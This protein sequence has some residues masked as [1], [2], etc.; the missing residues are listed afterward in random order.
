MVASV[1]TM[2]LWV[3]ALDHLFQRNMDGDRHDFEIARDEHHHG[4]RG[5]APGKL[6]EELGVAGKGEARAIEH[7]LADWVGDDGACIASSTR[8]TAR[9]IEMLDRRGRGRVRAPRDDAS[10]NGDRQHRQRLG[11]EPRRRG[12]L[13]DRLDRDG[14]TEDVGT[15]GKNLGIAKQDEGRNR[16]RLSAP[17]KREA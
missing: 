11:E 12:G 5:F 3:R 1:L 14:K 6:G 10:R 2:R 15:G 16:V 4:V 8:A 13:A 9:S 7:G 17:E